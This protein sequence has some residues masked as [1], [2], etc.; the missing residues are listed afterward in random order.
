MQFNVNEGIVKMLEVLAGHTN[1]QV[2]LILTLVI[3]KLPALIRELSL[4]IKAARPTDQ[5]L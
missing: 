2:L 4:L 3:L 1:L 5:D